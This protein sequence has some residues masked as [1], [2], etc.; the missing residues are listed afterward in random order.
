MSHCYVFQIPDSSWKLPRLSAVRK[1]FTR[2]IYAALSTLNLGR[3][4]PLA[5]ADSALEQIPAGF[6]AIIL[7]AALTAVMPFRLQAVH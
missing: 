5:L 4:M 1:S 3:Q 7:K 6:E 2:L